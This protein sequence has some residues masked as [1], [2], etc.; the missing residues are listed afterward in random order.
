MDAILLSYEKSQ[1]EIYIITKHIGLSPYHSKVIINKVDLANR[2]VEFH[3]NLCRG[4]IPINNIYE[5]IDI[6]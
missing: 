5:L 3:N 6:E 2:L 1:K 4:Y